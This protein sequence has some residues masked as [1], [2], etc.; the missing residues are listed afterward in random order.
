[1]D[2]SRLA[3][4]RWRG[5]LTNNLPVFGS[6]YHGGHQVRRLHDTDRSAWWALLLPDPVHRLAYSH[7]VFNCRAAPGENRFGPDPKLEQ[8]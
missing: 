2:K 1:M 8:E 7:P 4:C 3:T 5:V 6:Y